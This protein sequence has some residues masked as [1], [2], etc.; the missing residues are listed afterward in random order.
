[1]RGADGAGRLVEI[2]VCI[3]DGLATHCGY[4]L[5]ET[6]SEGTMDRGEYCAYQGVDFGLPGGQFLI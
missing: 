4:F 1:M 3:C 2:S 5:H 6:I